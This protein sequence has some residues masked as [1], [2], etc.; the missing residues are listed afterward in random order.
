MEKKKSEPNRGYFSLN[1][2]QKA[3]RRQSWIRIIKSFI[4]RGPEK[5]R[6]KSAG[7]IWDYVI[8]YVLLTTHYDLFG[9]AASVVYYLLL[10]FFPILI[11]TMYFISILTRNLDLSPDT[12]MMI[13]SFLP[14]P[15]LNIVTGLSTDIIAPI[16]R[17][18]LVASF[19]T[20]L[21]AASKGVGQVFQ[22]IARIYP[23]KEKGLSLS[24]R[25]AAIILTIFIFILLGLATLIMSFGRVVFHFIMTHLTFIRF[26]RSLIDIS[27]Y[28]IGFLL[29]FAILFILYFISTKRSPEKIPKVPGALFATIAWVAL[30]FF[31]SI[32]IASKANLDS[33]YGGLANIIILMLWL[34][35]TVQIILFGALINYQIAWYRKQNKHDYLILN[36][37]I[38]EIGDDENPFHHLKK[39]NLK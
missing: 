20:T 2:K 11:L 32:Y 12:I 39:E 4:L 25:A 9:Q 33:L 27:T 26:N 16:S 28:G 5:W 10:T 38:K 37:T 18:S 6:G 22:G 3:I 19:A 8:D 35:F 13:R 17:F 29:I 30:S 21:W 24:N 34:N 7:R 15:I 31:Y 14:E 1:K 36:E 23:K